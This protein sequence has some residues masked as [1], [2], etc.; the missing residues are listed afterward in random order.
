MWEYVVYGFGGLV[1]EIGEENGVME[2]VKVGGGMDESVDNTKHTTRGHF[3]SN[4]RY[5][6]CA[7]ATGKERRKAIPTLRRL[8]STDRGWNMSR[9]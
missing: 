4:T 6:Y 7:P 2:L 8:S 5:S 1:N 3:R 9:A